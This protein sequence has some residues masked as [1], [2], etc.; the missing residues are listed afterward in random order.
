MTNHKSH[1]IFI[2]L[3]ILIGIFILV[4]GI[5]YFQS[6]YTFEKIEPAVT[7]QNYD[8]GPLTKS[9]FVSNETEEVDD[10][11]P[12]TG[13]DKDELAFQVF[14]EEIGGEEIGKE[15]FSS[16]NNSQVLISKIT[17]ISDTKYAGDSSETMEEA[18]EVIAN[19]N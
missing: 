16:F 10:V 18:L 9:P 14:L 15:E 4:F 6:N 7:E 12:F 5:H 3:G 17:D 13:E 8:D 1:H 11:D 2:Y 19:F